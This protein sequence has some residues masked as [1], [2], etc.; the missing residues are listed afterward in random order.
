VLTNANL[1][2]ADLTGADLTL[3][4]LSGANL[5]GANLTNT[6][7][8]KTTLARATGL[9]SATGLDTL[10]YGDECSVDIHTLRIG[11]RVLPAELL[12]QCGLKSSEIE[13]LREVLGVERSAGQRSGA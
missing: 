10:R 4:N 6:L 8:S 11:L 3:A 1:E 7:W 5:G 13:A 2:S 9:E 12:A